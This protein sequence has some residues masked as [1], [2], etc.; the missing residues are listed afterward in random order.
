MKNTFLKMTS[1]LAITCISINIFAGCS[2]TD[3]TNLKEVA[4][5]SG[6]LS[7]DKAM[8]AKDSSDIADWTGKQLTL[9]YWK[10]NGTGGP[11]VIPAMEKDVVTPE[12]KRITGITIDQENS[13]SNGGMEFSAK[14]GLVTASEDWSALIISA[15]NPKDILKTGLFYDLTDLLPKYCPNIMKRVPPDKYEAVYFGVSNGEY[16]KVYGVPANWG[17]EVENKLYPELEN[18]ARYRRIIPK[19]QLYGS[20]KRFIV[21]DDILKMIY[22][23]AK[24]FDELTND[25]VTKGGFTKEEVY[26]PEI[27]TRE[28]AIEFLYK[29]KKVIDA[30][31]INE[32]NDQPVWTSYATTG[33]DQDNWALM[34]CLMPYLSGYNCLDFNYYCYYSKITKQFELP[35]LTGVY[36]SMLYDVNKMVRDGVLAK[37]SFTDDNAIFSNKMNN[38]QY[39]VNYAWNEPSNADLEKKGKS[40][41]YRPVWLNIPINDDT[42]IY[43]SYT[44][45]NTSQ[46]IYINKKNVSEEDLPQILRAIDF[47]FSDAGQLLNYWGPRS[48][49]IW[50]EKNG[51]RRFTV[52][53]LDDI[54]QEGYAGNYDALLTYGFPSLYWTFSNMGLADKKRMDNSLPGFAMI[55][56]IENSNSIKKPQYVYAYNRSTFTN[57]PEEMKT[58]FDPRIVDPPQTVL[59]KEGDVWNWIVP[60]TQLFADNVWSK[61]SI[62]DNAM[63][64]CMTGLTDENFEK[65]YSEFVRVGT[66]QNRM[67]EEMRKQIDDYYKNIFNKEWMHY[68]K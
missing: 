65:K 49:N 47:M 58:F 40:Y 25:F 20:F 7:L 67:N 6:L 57:R 60:Q 33:S 54:F 9:T 64:K 62:L 45:V 3:K 66:D 61:R 46:P 42:Y 27:N 12:I 51:V 14:L 23:D 21:R 15:Q 48:A 53:E 50:E 24:S 32:G 37:E 44:E 17:Q 43:D 31:N 8:A 68:L 1:F 56:F 16:G 2:K 5:E 11:S 29:I 39:A 55:S 18:D 26:Q 36:K 59:S 38:G 4:S 30:N 34:A 28:E 13:F 41:K 52:K 19:V 10:A 35:V 63:K 22:P